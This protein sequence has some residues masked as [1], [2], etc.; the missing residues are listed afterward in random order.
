MRFRSIAQQGLALAA[1]STSLLA[2]A[3]AQELNAPATNLVIEANDVYVPEVRLRAERHAALEN[4]EKNFSFDW[5]KSAT[6]A[7]HQKVIA[8]L[9]DFLKKTNDES[10]LSEEDQVVLGNLLYK[11]GT[12]YTHV[13]RQPDT[14]IDKLNSA[15]PLLGSKEDKAWNYNQ[16]AY[17]Y[18]Q[19]YSVTHVA[20]DKEKALYYS[21]KVIADIYPNVKNKAV[22]FAYCINGLIQNDAQDASQAITSFKTALSIYEALPGGKD[23]QYARLKNRLA[24]TILEQNNQDKDAIAM[25]EESKKYWLSQSNANHNPHAAKNLLSL[26]QAY[27]KI[28]NAKEAQDEIKKAVSIYQNVYGNH[29][30]QLVVPYQLLSLAYKKA[31]D[32]K[33]ADDYAQKA[34]TLISKQS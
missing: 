9:E 26:G 5:N 30:Q 21:N 28:G 15:G 12:Y 34:N 8:Q 14:A 25:L 13:S 18:E 32:E 1:L 7:G 19:K 27:L 20:A 17:A 2:F 4:F 23:D 16:L 33:L 3:E 22:A 29:S 24:D 11:L 6:I 31:G 10:D